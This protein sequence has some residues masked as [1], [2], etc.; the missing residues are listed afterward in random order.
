MGQISFWLDN[1]T[2]SVEIGGYD[3]NLFTGDIYYLSG[4]SNNYWAPIA[5]GLFYDGI[6]IDAVQG[7]PSIY[8]IEAGKYK[9]AVFDTG[10]SNM[11]LPLAVIKRLYSVW[12]IAAD[13]AGCD[14]D[15]AQPS[16]IFEIGCPCK[17]LVNHFKDLDFLINGDTH[18][19]LS[20]YAYLKT[21]EEFS[22]EICYV[23]IEAMGGEI[24]KMSMYLLGDTFLRHFYTIFNYELSGF[25]PPR[26]NIGLALNTQY[27]RD[28]YTDDP[29]I[30]IRKFGDVHANLKHYY[31]LQSL[32][33]FLTIFIYM[34]LHFFQNDK[35]KKRVALHALKLKAKDGFKN[36][37]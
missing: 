7:D 10:T 22:Q 33:C 31:I 13:L 14:T 5:N 9:M 34:A 35:M 32:V 23:G 3:S 28:G 20:A 12:Q 25:I 17:D 16:G 24:S 30:R 21:R 15:I 4:Y 8:E 27:V 6:V 37:L 36:S 1:M 18:I 29:P 26:R 11:A 19:T 2:A